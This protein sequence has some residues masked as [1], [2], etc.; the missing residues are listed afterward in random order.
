MAAR[1]K[2]SHE[3][4]IHDE[5]VKHSEHHNKAKKEH[6]K[7]GGSAGGEF[8]NKYVLKEAQEG[9]HGEHHIAGGTE[10]SKLGRKR[11]GKVAHHGHHGHHRAKGGEVGADKHPFSSAH[12]H[13]KDEE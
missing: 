11:G 2:K 9:A 7:N 5:S 6:L 3:K 12:Q 10:H 8:G 13:S 1:H 4:K